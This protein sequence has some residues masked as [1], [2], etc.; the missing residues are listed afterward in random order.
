MTTNTG[1]D[2]GLG[3]TKSVWLRF[4]HEVTER[5]L[6]QRGSPPAEMVTFGGYIRNQRYRS[7]ISLA[8]LAT[9]LDVPYEHLVLLEQG[10]LKPSEVPAPAWMRLVRILEGREQMLTGAVSQPDDDSPLISEE[11]FAAASAATGYGPTVDDLAP[12]IGVARV[13]V[14]GVGGGGTNAVSRMYRQRLPG[15]EYMAINTD[16]QHLLRSDVPMKFRIGDRLTRGLGVGGDAEMG[17]ESAEESR[18]DLYEAVRGCDLVFIAAGM[19]GGTGTGATP[20]VAEIARESGALTIAVVTKP[21]SFEGRQRTLQAEKGVVELRGKVDTLILIP[22]DRLL[23]I[24]DENMTANNAFKLADEVLRQ[25]IQAI[26]ELI[27]VPGEI[28]LDLAD[29]KA[30]MGD[31]GPA[32]MAIGTG[33]GENRAVNAARIALSSPLL[34]APIEGARRVLMN[35]TGGS[36]LTIQEVQEAAN[37]ISSSVDPEANIIFGMITDPKMEDEVQVTVIA[38]DLP[39]FDGDMLAAGSLETILEETV[40]ETMSAEAEPNDLGSL[41]KRFRN[42]GRGQ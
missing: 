29:V 36:D 23:S 7:G 8:D 26:A 33:R 37:F 11:G 18:E 5:W 42:I 19:G 1:E 6:Q 30:V 39:A 3:M 24:S 16:A 10:L 12:A 31:A 25:G 27:T 4:A 34:D 21:F 41:W 17:R 9:D 35:I 14:I 2:T 20:V 32:W 40:G 13:R 28:N 38:T 15:V 22:N